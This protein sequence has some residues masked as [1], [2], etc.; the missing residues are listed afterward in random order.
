MYLRPCPIIS[1]LLLLVTLS[2]YFPFCPC[3]WFR[4]TVTTP[5]HHQNSQDLS[6]M[7][8]CHFQSTSSSPSPL[9][10]LLDMSSYVIQGQGFVIIC[11]FPWFPLQSL[12]SYDF[13]MSSN[14]G[15]GPDHLREYHLLKTNYP[16]KLVHH[17]VLRTKLLINKEWSKGA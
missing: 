17:H 14:K 5:H 16:I 12:I 9:P 3:L 13:N 4:C 1:G 6:S 2:I 8:L 7:F 10:L 11:P 15:S